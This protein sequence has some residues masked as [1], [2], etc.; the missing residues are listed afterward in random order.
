MVKHFKY[1]VNF[2]FAI[3]VGSENTVIN[4]PKLIDRRIDINAGN[5]PYAPYDR[6]GI[7]AVL[8]A[9]QLNLFRAI[10]VHH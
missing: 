5:N 7:A 4:N 9:Y 6:F 10:L 2:A 8:A 3:I 1:V